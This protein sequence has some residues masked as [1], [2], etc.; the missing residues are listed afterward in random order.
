MEP[1][2]NVFKILRPDEVFKDNSDLK[3]G[4]EI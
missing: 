4:D 1:N 2:E 3:P